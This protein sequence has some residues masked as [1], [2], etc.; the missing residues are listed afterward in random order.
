MGD[1]P[2]WKKI[3]PSMGTKQAI[4]VYDDYA[5]KYVDKE[6]ALKQSPSKNTKSPFGALTGG[7]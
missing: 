6:P 3:G 5:G 7:K 1:S 2:D 4:E